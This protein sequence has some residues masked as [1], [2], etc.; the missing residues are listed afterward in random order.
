MTAESE[1][2]ELLRDVGRILACE[3]GVARVP[4]IAS[5]PVAVGTSGHAA[6][7]DPALSQRLQD[8]RAAR[9]AAVSE[10]PED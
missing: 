6:L 4:W 2:Q 10:A 1:Q 3:A 8:W 9:T 7:G 5:R